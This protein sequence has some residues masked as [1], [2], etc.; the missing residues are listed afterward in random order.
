M[1]SVKLNGKE[2]QVNNNEFEHQP[3][4]RYTNLLI[5]KDVGY[6][7]R[8]VSLISELSCLSVKNLIIYHLFRLFINDF[9]FE[10]GHII[11]SINIEGNSPKSFWFILSA[12]N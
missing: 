12:K 8:V 9:S 11:W 2:F 3:H 1:I 4:E 5:R 7:E 10:L 6:L